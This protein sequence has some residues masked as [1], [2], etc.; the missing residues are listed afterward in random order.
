MASELV[1]ALNEFFIGAGGAFIL[2]FIV[3]PIVFMVGITFLLRQIINDP[4]EW[5]KTIWFAFLWMIIFYL[6]GLFLSY[7]VFRL[8]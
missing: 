6:I 1:S 2:W 4:P 8:F 7:Q 3:F 5:M